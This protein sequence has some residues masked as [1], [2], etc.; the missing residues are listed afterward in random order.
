MIMKKIHN[1][2]LGLGT[3]SV[4]CFSLSIPVPELSAMSAPWGM[5]RITVP[6]YDFGAVVSAIFSIFCLSIVLVGRF[7]KLPDLRQKN[8][9]DII[10]AVEDLDGISPP[11]YFI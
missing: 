9:S 6:S 7:K 4:L 11:N 1:L 2:F 3:F 5:Q 8:E 10:L